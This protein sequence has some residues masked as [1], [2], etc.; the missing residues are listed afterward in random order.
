MKDR[1]SAAANLRQYRSDCAQE[2]ARAAFERRDPE[3]PS[4]DWLSASSRAQLAAALAR[5][6][7]RAAKRR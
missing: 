4:L 2:I 3:Q 6:E 1:H 5:R 7:R